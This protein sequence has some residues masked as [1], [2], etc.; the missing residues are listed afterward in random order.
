MSPTQLLQPE[1]LTTLNDLFNQANAAFVGKVDPNTDSVK[2]G[3]V[4]IYYDIQ[5]LATF[6]VAPCTI[7]N[8]QSACAERG[9]S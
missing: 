9:N 4:Q 6:D 5:A 3:V 7:N 8:G 1:T 2:E